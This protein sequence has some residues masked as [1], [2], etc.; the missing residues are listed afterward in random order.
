VIDLPALRR[1]ILEAREAREAAVARACAA[2]HAVVA[3]SVN[4]PGPDKCPPGARHLTRL[5]AAA[6]AGRE[7]RAW[8]L[9]GGLDAL[10]PW[11]TFGTALPPAAA[12]RAAIDMETTL[13]AGRVLDIDVYD[14]TG[15]QTD[16]ASLGLPA[17]SCVICASPA[18]ECM[19]VGRHTADDV[20]A[21][22]AE[23][24]LRVLASALADGA[25]TELDVTPKPGLVDRIDNGSHPDLSFEDMSRS[26]DLLP[27]YFDELL[28]LGDP[29]ALSECIAAGQR[30]E[31]RMVEA[32]GANAHKGYIFLAGLVLLAA[33]TAAD[34]VTLRSG[35][36]T[37]AREVLG[38]RAVRSA[39]TV[40]PSNGD[41]VRADYGVGGI[42]RETL[43]GLPS[44][45]ERGL[46][47]L[48][49]HAG[50]TSKHLLM[51]TL[52]QTV[53]DT[54]AVHRCGPDGLARLRTDGLLLQRK[55]EGAED[56]LPWLAALN[57][58]YRRLGLT[59]GGVADCMA[60]SFALDRWF[61]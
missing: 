44:V 46:P 14:S 40:P 55:I 31:R 58:D 29:P 24:L 18:A 4:I 11:A 61:D 57:D 38:A 10:G 3:V 59:M 54:T 51:A 34:P 21:A 19:R 1:T 56:Y 49:S 37:L 16:R 8:P 48:A 47:A 41:R 13:P 5:A 28:G 25:R 53:E 22:A 35:I 42:V 30:A 6:A 17:R 7:L 15:S 9:D 33:R 50:D 26:V 36:A 12:K 39:T 60:L 32:I 43:D 2:A 45:F 23:L 27:V 20:G 52:M